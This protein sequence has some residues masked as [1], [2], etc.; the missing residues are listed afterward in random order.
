MYDITVLTLI[1]RGGIP[2][3]RDEITFYAV[4]DHVRGMIAAS[5]KLTLFRLMKLPEDTSE[6]A[7]DL[8]YRTVVREAGCDTIVSDTRLIT[9]PG[10]DGKSMAEFKYWAVDQLRETIGAVNAEL[11]KGPSARKKRN[12]AVAFLKLIFGRTDK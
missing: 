2:H 9:F 8:K 11:E 6:L 4:G 10:M 3:A 12:R 5:C 1:S 7:W